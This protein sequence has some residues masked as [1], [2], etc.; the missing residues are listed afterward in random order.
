MKD[1]FLTQKI[2][3]TMPKLGSPF[4][5]L[6]NCNNKILN[7]PQTER[8]TFFWFG[9]FSQWHP[10]RFEINNVTYTHAEQWMMAEKARMFHDDATL[11]LILRAQTPKL[12]KSLGRKVAPFNPKQWD[13]SARAIVKKGNRAKFLQNSSMKEALLATAGT[14]LVE[15]SPHDTIWGI[16]LAANDPRARNR[17]EWRGK[18]WLGEVLTELRD[19]ML[20]QG[21][22]A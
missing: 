4:A 1:S 21:F 2:K 16:G 12:Q 19:E 3:S 9:T 11:E 22:T 7:A 20:G 5:Q 15:A 13:Q 10:S 8:F 17:S 18:N 6:H 14:T